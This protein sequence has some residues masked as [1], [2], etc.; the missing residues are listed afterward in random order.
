MQTLTE[1]PLQ[2]VKYIYRQ[3]IE[4]I[5]IESVNE[6]GFLD[7]NHARKSIAYLW[8]HNFMVHHKNL[9]LVSIN[10][11]WDIFDNMID[12]LDCCEIT[13]AVCTTPTKKYNPAF[14]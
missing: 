14:Y 12:Y 4:N 5:I 10:E 9:D 6:D 3:S 11:V 1:L 8:F 2:Q 13:S 7:V